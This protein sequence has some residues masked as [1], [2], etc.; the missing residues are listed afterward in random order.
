MA[1]TPRGASRE[2]KPL[3]MSRAGFAASAVPTALTGLPDGTRGV[4]EVTAPK[5]RAMRENVKERISGRTVRLA[6]CTTR[7]ECEDGEMTGSQLG[8]CIW[9]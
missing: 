9:A 1:A 6:V 3:T 4:A 5:Q 2:F 8:K 7:V